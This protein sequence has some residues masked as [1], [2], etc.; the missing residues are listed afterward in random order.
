ME[1]EYIS[2]TDT[3][4]L[5]RLVLKESFPGVKFSVKSSKYSGGASVD[6]HY[7]DGPQ[8]KIIMEAV[9]C[10]SGAY[11]DGMIDYQGTVYA[12]LDGQPVRF[13]ANFVFANQT[14]SDPVM[15]RGIWAFILK[16]ENNSLLNIKEWG[17][18]KVG[19]WS[20]TKL[21][22]HYKRG[23]FMNEYLTGIGSKDVHR[24][25]YE[26][27]LEDGAIPTCESKTRARVTVTHSDGYGNSGLPDENGKSCKG[28]PEISQGAA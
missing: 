24:L 22:D 8:E 23:L 19:E 5:I 18:H 15:Q 3:A 7:T 25:I 26:S 16:Y 10:F 6:I 1:R 17:F 11:F 2:V 20:P 27:I 12:T 9:D 14:H 13:G 28:Y 21:L 4:K